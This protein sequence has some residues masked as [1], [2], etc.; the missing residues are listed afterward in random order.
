MNWVN[1]DF[2]GETLTAL[3]SGAL[4]WK[5]SGL[6]V[7][8]DLHLGKSERIARRGHSDAYVRTIMYASILATFPAVAAPLMGSKVLTLVVLWP[9]VLLGAAYLGV[10]AASFQP[11]TPNQMRGQTTAIYIFVTNIFGLAV[12]TS[13]LAAFTDFLY[14]D[15]GLLHYSIATAVAIFYPAAALLFWYCLP[16]Y[17]EA[18]AETGNWKF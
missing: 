3:P 10:M 9:A 7:V 5:R 17:R 1:F 12:G 18:V 2:Q 14:Q 8:S 11:I 13:V 16:A 15:D 6:L 4:F